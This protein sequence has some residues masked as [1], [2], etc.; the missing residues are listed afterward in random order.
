MKHS[1]NSKLKTQKA[2]VI[3]LMGPPGSGKGT[4]AILLCDK[5]TNLYYFETSKILEEKFA[6]IKKEKE[7][8]VEGKKYSILKE[9]KRWLKGELCS[10]PFVTFLV[11]EKIEELF[12]EGMNLVLAGSPRTVYE[13]ERIIPQI[14][15]LYGK[16]NIKI[17]LLEI[18][19]EETIKRNSQRKICELMRHPIIFSPQ[20]KN[21]KICPLDGSKLIKRKGLDDPKTIV[22]RIEAYQKETLPVIDYFKKRNYKVIKINGSPPPVKVFNEILKHLK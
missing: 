19:P 14:E 8:E 22:K 6:E 10:P 4:Q 13:A 16:E 7:I 15:K 9:K 17:F 12:R 1:D 20:T 11:K 2:K 5:F 21:L 18:P 3:I